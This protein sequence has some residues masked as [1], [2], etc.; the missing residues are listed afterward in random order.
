[1]GKKIKTHIVVE[2][3]IGRVSLCGEQAMGQYAVV[4]V[5][6]ICK[7]VGHNWFMSCHG[8]AVR[9]SPRTNGDKYNSMV[10]MHHDII[11]RRPGFIIDHVDCDKL[12]NTRNNLH[13]VTRRHNQLNKRYPNQDSTNPYLGVYLDKRC[14]RWYGQITIDGKRVHLG[15]HPTP[16]SANAIVV[17]IRAGVLENPYYES[18]KRQRSS[19]DM[20]KID[21]SGDAQD[22]RNG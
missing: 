21:I 4:D 1:M 19:S 2:G 10:F 18:K 6:D 5:D 12:N 7:I 20:E 14:N 8:Y 22:D 13:H 9:S 17:G 11:G 15:M 3:A 16:E